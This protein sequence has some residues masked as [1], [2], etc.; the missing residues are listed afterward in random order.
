MKTERVSFKHDGRKVSL[1]L[2]RNDYVTKQ[3]QKHGDFYEA[4]FLNYLLKEK[5]IDKTIAVVDVGAHAGNHTV[6]FGIHCLSV[7]AFEPNIDVYALL[8]RNVEE[9]GL[10]ETVLCTDAALAARR[11][12]ISTRFYD[13]NNTGNLFWWYGDEKGG[14][15]SSGKSI[16]KVRKRT[17]ADALVLDDAILGPVDFLKI[18]AEGMELEVLKGAEKKIE[19]WSP[20]IMVEVILGKTSDAVEEWLTDRGYWKDLGWAKRPEICPTW[21]MRKKEDAGRLQSEDRERDEDPSSEAG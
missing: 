2:P 4:Q 13:P 14:F 9:N 3:I 20:M 6:F 12:E 19:E 21:L 10:D 17:K 15:C 8:E 16:Q 1:I 11:G 5:L 7:H 18:D